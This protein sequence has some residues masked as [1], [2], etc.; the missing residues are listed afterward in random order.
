MPNRYVRESAIESERVNKLGWQAEVFWRRLL[1]K[2]DDFGRFTAH[3]ELLRAAVFPMQLN[4]VSAADVGK[5]LLECEQ[6][7]LIST[8]KGQLDGKPYLVMQ[9]WE[10]GR[11]KESKYPK[12]PEDVCACLHV[13]TDAPDSDDDSDTDSEKRGGAKRTPQLTDE[14]WLKGLSSEPCYNHCRVKDEY[15]KMLV[16][17]KNQRPPKQPTRRRFINWLNRIER[18]LGGVASTAASKTS[19]RLLPEQF[20]SWMLSQCRKE[21]RDKVAGWKTFA[22]LPNGTGLWDEWRREQTRTA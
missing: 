22:D 14:E 15:G 13:R 17:C 21:D 9:K 20:R 18:P 2:V 10:Q 7:S 8:W 1:N 12:P 11:A 4:K 6:A 16:W 5:L 19:P 3:P